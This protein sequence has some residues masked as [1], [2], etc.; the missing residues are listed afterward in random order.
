LPQGF[1]DVVG[2]WI[3]CNWRTGAH[4]K[5]VPGCYDNPKFPNNLPLGVIHSLPRAATIWKDLLMVVMDKSAE[6]F[7]LGDFDS[8]SPNGVA[9]TMSIPLQLTDT[10]DLSAVAEAS[11]DVQ[12]LRKER[13]ALHILF[14]DNQGV[15]P[16]PFCFAISKNQ[17]R[18]H[19]HPPPRLWP[20]HKA[21]LRGID[22]DIDA[23][24]DATLHLE[25]EKIP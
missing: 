1:V 16:L 9:A 25:P 12:T 2:A 15:P 3:S 24:R 18:S 4:L 22:I 10:S 7:K 17:L 13:E 19:F 21:K 20:G 6:L 23:Q 8:Q 11:F 5:L 14:R